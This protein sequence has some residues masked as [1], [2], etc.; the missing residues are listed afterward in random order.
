MNLKHIYR[1]EHWSDVCLPRRREV[2]RSYLSSPIER[3]DTCKKTS[4][5]RKQTK[6]SEIKFINWK[7]NSYL[8]FFYLLFWSSSFGETSNRRR[9]IFSITS[10]NNIV[11]QFRIMTQSRRISAVTCIRLTSQSIDITPRRALTEGISDFIHPF[12]RHAPTR[13]PQRKNWCFQY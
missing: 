1:H 9:K 6:H 11:L 4:W 2:R 7:E 13:C 8:L 5:Y 10:V 3:T 12:G